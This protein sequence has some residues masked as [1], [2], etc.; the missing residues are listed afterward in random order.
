MCSGNEFHA[1]IGRHARKHVC[2]FKFA[3]STIQIPANL[4]ITTLISVIIHSWALRED[5]LEKEFAKISSDGRKVFLGVQ[6]Y[7]QF[8]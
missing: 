4:A 6:Y 2:G 8:N 7:T 1:A 5:S 3:K